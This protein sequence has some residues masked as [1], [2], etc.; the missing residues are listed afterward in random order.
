M[1]DTAGAGTGRGIDI[2]LLGGS[3]VVIVKKFSCGKD[4]MI[5][6]NPFLGN[7]HC[8][9]VKE[10]INSEYIVLI[11]LNSESVSRDLILQLWDKVDLKICAGNLSI[12]IMFSAQLVIST[13]VFVHNIT[14]VL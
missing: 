12:M 4:W 11:I 13:S 5:H 9:E 14:L 3:K 7:G 6:F 8:T 10:G 2:L 1:L